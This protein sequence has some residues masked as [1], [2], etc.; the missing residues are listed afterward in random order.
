MREVVNLNQ[1]WAF[2]K[3]IN[4][5]SETDGQELLLTLNEQLNKIKK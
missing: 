3:K 4:G 5:N 1:K 2:S